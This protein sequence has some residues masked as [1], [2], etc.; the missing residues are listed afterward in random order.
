MTGTTLDVSEGGYAYIQLDEI[1]YLNN[2]VL[3]R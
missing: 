3:P 1:G 2:T